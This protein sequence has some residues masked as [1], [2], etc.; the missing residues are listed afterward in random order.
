MLPEPHVTARTLDDGRMV[1][2][3]TVQWID[4]FGNVQLSVPGHVLAGTTSA[5]VIVGDDD[6]LVRVVRAYADLEVG[7]AG[8]LCDANG[9]VALVVGEGSAM[10]RFGV[11]IGDRVDLVGDFVTPT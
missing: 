8:L 10:Q 4:R 2:T 5:G 6:A 7:A 3:G 9:F 1:L 11:T